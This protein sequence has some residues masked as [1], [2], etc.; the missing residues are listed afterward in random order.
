MVKV[1]RKIT[2]PWHNLQTRASKEGESFSEFVFGHGTTH[3]PA[4]AQ[5]TTHRILESFDDFVSNAGEEGFEM[6]MGGKERVATS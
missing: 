6:V 4:L 3:K 5:P 2:N 1:E